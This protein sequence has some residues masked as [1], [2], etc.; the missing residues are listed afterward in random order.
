MDLM[1]D[2]AENSSGASRLIALQPS[3]ALRERGFASGDLAPK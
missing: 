2:D 3:L 1:R